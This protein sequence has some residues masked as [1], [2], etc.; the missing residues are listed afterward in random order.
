VLQFS[1]DWRHFAGTYAGKTLKVY[2]D[3]KLEGTL[4]A[5]GEIIP[6]DG[7]LRFSKECCGANLTRTFVGALDESLISDEVLP[8]DEIKKLMNEG[9]KRIIAVSSRDKFATTWGYIKSAQ[10]D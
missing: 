1:K 7:N 3:G 6:G 8:E 4:E 10:A 5:Q 2:I 9:L